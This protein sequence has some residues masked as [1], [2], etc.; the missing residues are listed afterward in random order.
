MRD[1][2]RQLDPAVAEIDEGA[3]LEALTRV[4]DAP[5]IAIVVPADMG[6]ASPAI[7]A[8]L[9]APA[10]EESLMRNDYGAYFA[11]LPATLRAAVEERWGPAERD[12]AFREGRLDCGRFVIPARRRG[13]AV[14]VLEPEGGD[15]AVPSHGCLALYAWLADGFRARTILRLRRKTAG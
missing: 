8:L 12:P 10:E 7:D 5:R 6:S 4:P 9:A 3:A 15:A 11:T 1:W 13:N 2:R 14:A